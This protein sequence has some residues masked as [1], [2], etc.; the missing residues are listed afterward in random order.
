MTEAAF[1][2]AVV[3]GLDRWHGAKPDGG[4]ADAAVAAAKAAGLEFA[5][6]APTLPERL[7]ILGA[8][9]RSAARDSNSLVARAERGYGGFDLDETAAIAVLAEAVRRYNSWPA[10]Y[11]WASRHHA[12]E[13]VAGLLCI[14]EGEFK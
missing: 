7:E 8:C 13:G 9:V 6:E 4:I 11:A 12:G 14:L 10:F 1:R 5:P 2:R 3:D